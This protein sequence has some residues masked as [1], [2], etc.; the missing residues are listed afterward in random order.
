MLTRVT[1]ARYAVFSTQ[2]QKECTQDDALMKNVSASNSLAS[3]L[4]I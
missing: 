3:T 2:V 1:E 4:A